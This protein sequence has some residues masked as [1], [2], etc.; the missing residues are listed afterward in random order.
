MTA[1]RLPVEL[2]LHLPA[3]VECHGQIATAKGAKPPKLM[4]AMAHSAICLPM[5]TLA[6][7]PMA[8]A[9][10]PATMMEQMLHYVQPHKILLHPH[11]C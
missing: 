2:Q 5:Q 10:L 8:D 4:L 9:Q 1:K 6:A 11:R 3:R 7:T